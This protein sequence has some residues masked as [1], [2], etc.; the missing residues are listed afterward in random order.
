M[1]NIVIFCLTSCIFFSSATFFTAPVFANDK[2]MIVYRNPYPE[3][4]WINVGTITLDPIQINNAVNVRNV[5][6]NAISKYVGTFGGVV[7]NA[8][9]SAI[10]SQFQAGTYT[11]YIRLTQYISTDYQRHYYTYTVYKDAACRKPIGTYVSTKWQKRYRK[12]TN[13]SIHL[14]INYGQKN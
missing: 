5:V 7:N 2:S 6:Y 1:R 10:T 12:T 9:I 3:H 14:I 13:S 4:N 11:F 8:I